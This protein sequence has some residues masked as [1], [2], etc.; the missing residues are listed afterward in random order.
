MNIVR[1]IF[2]KHHLYLRRKIL[3]RVPEH[4]LY[5]HKRKCRK[6]IGHIPFIQLSASDF[7]TGLRQ[8]PAPP[9]PYFC[10][11]CQQRIRKPC[12]SGYHPIQLFIWHPD[13]RAPR[14]VHRIFQHM[15]DDHGFVEI[16]FICPSFFCLFFKLSVLQTH[17]VLCLK[18]Q[19]IYILL[20]IR[21]MQYI[22]DP[23]RIIPGKFLMPL[24]TQRLTLYK[25]YSFILKCVVINTHSPSLSESCRTF[26]F[27]LYRTLPATYFFT[28][29]YHTYSYHRMQVVAVHWL[30]SK[31]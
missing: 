13:T 29:K 6:L 7:F 15:I 2:I 14:H 12:I 23:F 3:I 10:K 4:Q 11:R 16:Q 25:R 19:Q 21:K 20:I 27:C 28:I 22:R 31:Q 30:A 18:I 1:R 26:S 9:G 5:L 24:L 17:S 8:F